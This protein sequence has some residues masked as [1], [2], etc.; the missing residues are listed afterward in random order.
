[1]FSRYD[2]DGKLKR[3]PVYVDCSEDE[4]ITEQNHKQEVDINNIIRR[5]G[6]DMIQATSKLS[7]IN[8]QFDDVTG[9]DFQEAMNKVLKAQDTFDTLPSVIRKEF[10]N[11]PAIFLDFIQ[12]PENKDRMIEMGLAQAPV[13]EPP[14]EV[15]VT[16][17][18]TTPTE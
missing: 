11:N 16:N 8:F 6:L 12:N 15:V 4:I 9:N 17:P 5:H 7:S 2:A 3:N 1:M 13:V 10:D 18:T 14:V